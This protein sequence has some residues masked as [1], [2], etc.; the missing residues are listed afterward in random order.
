MS[1][2]FVGM[3]RIHAC[4]TT[5]HRADDLPKEGSLHC[6]RPTSTRR[7]LVDKLS[8][9]HSEARTEKQT[10]D[11]WRVDETY[12]KIKK[13]WMYLYRAVDSQGNTLEFLLSPTR[14]RCT[15]CQAL[16]SQN[17]LTATHTSEPRVINVD[18]NATYPKAFNEL[19]TDG[20]MPE[21]CE[22]R[23]VKYLN[24]LV[25]QDPHFINRL[26]KSGLGFFSLLTA[27]RTAQGYERKKRNGVTDGA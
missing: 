17:P 26:V 16:L 1:P 20:M 3:R 8:I 18:K 22:L 2:V 11:S 19:K 4:E 12:I 6:T 24:N 5:L 7:S 21:G 10:A 13:Q 15:S 9:A 25:E 27:Q 23:Q 14:E